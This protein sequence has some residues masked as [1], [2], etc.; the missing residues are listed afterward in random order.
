[1]YFLTKFKSYQFEGYQCGPRP[2]CSYNLICDYT[3][4][5]GNILN[6]LADDNTSGRIQMII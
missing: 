1:M 2:D 6:V 5:P 3:V 4:W